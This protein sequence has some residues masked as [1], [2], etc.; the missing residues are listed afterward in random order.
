MP[1]QTGFK[2]PNPWARFAFRISDQVTKLIERHSRQAEPSAC[3]MERT[4]RG[5]DRAIDSNPVVRVWQGVILARD[6][7]T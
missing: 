7:S 5:L 6:V 1:L 2:R 4:H 3:L